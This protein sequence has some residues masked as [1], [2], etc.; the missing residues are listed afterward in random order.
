[1]GAS[2]ILYSVL[3]WCRSPVFDFPRLVG[4]SRGR[5]TGDSLCHV[6][7]PTSFDSREYKSFAL[8]I[9]KPLGEVLNRLG[10]NDTR[11]GILHPLEVHSVDAAGNAQNDV[12]SAVVIMHP[13]STE[14]RSHNGTVFLSLSIN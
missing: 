6:R 3:H 7:L 9:L 4:P 10:H 5:R 11:S 14:C 13:K 1:M 8:A 12:T 2:V